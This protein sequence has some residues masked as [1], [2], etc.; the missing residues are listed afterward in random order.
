M[1]DKLYKV[2]QIKSLLKK[3]RCFAVKTLMMFKR[4]TRKQPTSLRMFLRNQMLLMFVNVRIRMTYLSILYTWLT[5][6]G[7][8]YDH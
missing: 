8:K 7:F 5:Y 4:L 6:V 1:N 3:C 2:L